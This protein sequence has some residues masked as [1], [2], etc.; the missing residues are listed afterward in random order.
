M[1]QEAG[2]ISDLLEE[3]EF[4]DGKNLE[5]I[6]RANQLAEV[7]L[8]DAFGFVLISASHR[9][10]RGDLNSFWELDRQSVELALNG[11]Q[12]MKGFGLFRG[13]NQGC[14]TS[15]YIRAEFGCCTPGVE[16]AF[17]RLLLVTVVAKEQDLFAVEGLSLCCSPT[18]DESKL[19]LCCCQVGRLLTNAGRLCI[20]S[21]RDGLDAQSP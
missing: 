4:R 19:R 6:Q 16:M 12:G 5:E 2:W 3:E 15:G 17:D 11:N 20:P 10:D 1:V 8:C 18:I 21:R 7:S 14:E 13:G 9:L